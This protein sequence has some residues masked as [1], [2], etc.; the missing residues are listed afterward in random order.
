MD[1]LYAM[2]AIILCLGGLGR[3]GGFPVWRGS[4][5]DFFICGIG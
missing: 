2:G 4:M 3:V 1:F 5:R